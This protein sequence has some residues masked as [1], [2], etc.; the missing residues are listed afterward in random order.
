M[1]QIRKLKVQYKLLA[2]QRILL[3]FL[4][5]SRRSAIQNQTIQPNLDISAPYAEETGNRAFETSYLVSRNEFPTKISANLVV[6]QLDS[7]VEEKSK[8]QRGN[9][10]SS[11][12]T[13]FRV[14]SPSM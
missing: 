9:G 3:A 1:K 13:T 2:M 5:R 10:V 11:S 4:S 12:S 8:Y 7:Q 6:A 14:L